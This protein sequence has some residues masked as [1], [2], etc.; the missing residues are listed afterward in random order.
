MVFS[1]VYKYSPTVLNRTWVIL[2]EN[3]DCYGILF[4]AFAGVY[5]FILVITEQH[6][7]FSFDACLFTLET[8]GGIF[9]KTMKNYK[10]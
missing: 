5:V 4:L 9:S 3:E 6:I 7:N 8:K 1:L 10:Y 2:Y